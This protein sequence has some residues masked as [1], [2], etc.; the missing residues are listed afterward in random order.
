MF[1]LLS[2]PTLRYICGLLFC[3]PGPGFCQTGPSGYS[4]AENPYPPSPRPD[5]IILNVTADP[6]VS[7][8]VN[9]RSDT[10]VGMAYAEIMPA[11]AD[12]GDVEQARR[13]PASTSTLRTEDDNYNELSWKGVTAN[14]H[15]LVFRD[16]QPG[17]LY[18][19]RV[20]SDSG[21]S[22]W[23]QFRTAGREDDKLSFIYM[24]DAQTDVHS[25]WS[26][27]IRRA[28]SQMPEAQ[29]IVHAGDLINRANRDEEWG[30]WFEA[31]SFIHASLP[32]MPTPGNHEHADWG[33]KEDH[34]SAFWRPQFTLPENGPGG[35][36]ESCYYADVQGVRF[37]SLNSNLIEESKEFYTKQ[38]EWLEK[39][40]ANN[41]NRW[42][43]IVLHHPFYSTDGDRD[44]P[45]LRKEFKPLL[46]RYGVDLV[47]QGHDHGYGRGMHTIPM[48][49]NQEPGTMYVVSV[50]GPKMYD[51]ERKEWM[52]VMAANTQLYQLITIDGGTLSYK[53][54]TATGELYDAFDLIKRNGKPNK[55][56]NTMPR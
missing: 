16:L 40:L 55:V 7:M 47:M 52:E 46:D 15:S 20:G 34:L 8:A 35:L 56:V 19:Y 9:W 54:Y 42:T 22:E 18:E 21:W 53:A 32:A 37:I 5:R 29:L 17:R 2:T 31:G 48:E 33:G 3:L 25:M 12:P 36:E 26:K 14:Y 43:C 24:G 6:S 38:K 27:V 28:W 51:V 39:V 13:L 1:L 23:F 11:S 44:N 4:V 45:W 50:S 10:T 49:G 30:E 41:P